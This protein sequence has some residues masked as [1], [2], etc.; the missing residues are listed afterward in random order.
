MSRAAAFFFSELCE[1]VEETAL[2]E[3]PWLIGDLNN[4]GVASRFEHR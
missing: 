1:Y 4:V 2:E 3:C